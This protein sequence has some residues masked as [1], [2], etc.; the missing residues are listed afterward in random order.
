ML[1]ILKSCKYNQKEEH[2]RLKLVR[3]WMQAVD[4]K[5]S[6]SDAE[7]V[8]SKLHQCFGEI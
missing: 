5:L 8:V 1:C 2:E 3:D 4:D 7:L 6:V